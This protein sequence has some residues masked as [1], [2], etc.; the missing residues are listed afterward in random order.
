MCFMENTQEIS[1]SLVCQYS[2]L[3]QIG[4]EVGGVVSIS[5]ATLSF[6]LSP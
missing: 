2:E 6:S 4:I 5:G 3:R 1:R